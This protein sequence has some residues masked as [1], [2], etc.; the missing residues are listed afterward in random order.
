MQTQI[1]HIIHPHPQLYLLTLT[2]PPALASSYRR[3]F[4]PSLNIPH[5]PG[6]RC[7]Q[8]PVAILNSNAEMNGKTRRLLTQGMYGIHYF[9]REVGS[10][11]KPIQRSV[12]APL[13]FRRPTAIVS[14]WG[15]TNASF[16]QQQY[17]TF[18]DL[19][20]RRVQYE[21]ETGNWANLRI[22]VITAIVTLVSFNL[23]LPLPLSFS[24]WLG[25]SSH[26]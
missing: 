2:M 18:L 20:R 16:Q 11:P 1:V 13:S 21:R 22:P 3:V 14:Q 25:Y 9:N 8:W 7:S 15:F 26:H 23:P 6:P 17:R 19:Y 12:Q 5:L 4:N 10:M 24:L